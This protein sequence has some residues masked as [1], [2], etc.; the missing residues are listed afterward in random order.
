[1]ATVLTLALG[2]AVLAP[3]VI[4][5]AEAA[6]PLVVP[7][8][9]TSVVL[10]NVEA[11]H[12]PDKPCFHYYGAGRETNSST[13]IVTG[14][15]G[16]YAAVSYGQPEADK[17]PNSYGTDPMQ[18][19][20]SSMSLKPSKTT[21][22]N[23]GEPFLLGTMRHN[24]QPIFSG[25]NTS[26]PAVYSGS[27]EIKTAGT[28][29]S[30]FPWAEEDTVNDCTAELD[31]YGHMVIGSNGGGHKERD[32]RVKTKY[33][34]NQNHQVG[35][36]GGQYIYDY[37]GKP[38]YKSSAGD[39]YFYSDDD[40]VTLHDA[41]GQACSDD[42]LSIRSDRSQTTWRDPA[43]GIE[44]QLKIWGFT[45]NGEN[46]QCSTELAEN[47]YVNEFFVT[48]EKRTSYGCLYGSIEQLRPITFQTDA[49]ADESV[50]NQL[51]NPP[52]FDYSNTSAPGS[53]G[54][55]H[56]G[57]KLD[58]LTPT[59]W[60]EAGRSA[61][62]QVYTL[63]APNDLASATQDAQTKQ[64]KVQADGT[65]T[66]SGWYLNG[67][68]CLFTH[69]PHDPLLMNAKHGGGRLDR[70]NNVD[71]TNRS[72]RL[73]QSELA[74]NFQQAAVNCTWHNE[75]ILATGQLTLKNIVDSGSASPTEWTLTATPKEAG[76]FGQKIITGA[77][78]TASV[79]SQKTTGGTYVLSTTGGP[80]GYVQ[81]GDWTCTGATV[82]KDNGTTYAVLGEGANAT[83]TIHHK[84]D[85]TPVNAT[86]T[87]TGAT[88]AA[89][90]TEY[91][92]SYSCTPPGGGPAETGT[93]KAPANGTPV[94][95]AAMK[96]GA[97]CTVT[98]QQLTDAHLSTPAADSGTLTWG[99][100]AFAVTVGRNGANQPVATKPV[101][102]AGGNGPGV[103]F[104]VPDTTNG[105]L[106]VTV[107]NTVI[108]HA[109]VTKSFESVAKAAAQVGGK[110]TFDQTY[111]VTVKNPST[112]A[113]L[114]YTLTDTVQL[115]AGTTVNT[116]TITR[117]D[118]TV[119]AVPA[120][121]TSWTISDVTLP[122]AGTH[123]YTAVMN[124]SAPDP[125]LP[126]LAAGETC[127][128]NAATNGKAVFNTAGLTTKGDANAVAAKACGSVP[129]NPKFSVR[130]EAGAVT[131][132]LDGSGYT[133][134]YTVTVT[135]HSHVDSTIINDVR[136]QLGLPAS[137]K[138]TKAEVRENGNLVKTITGAE[139]TDPKGFV[140]AA[141]GSGQP[142]A[143][144]PAGQADG[145]TRVLGVQVHFTVDPYAPGFTTEDYT[146]GKTRA[147]G[148][149]AGLVNTAIM[150][151]DVDG[152]DNDTACLST[153]A[154]LHFNKTVT[155]RPG[156]G[157]TFDVGYTITVENQG[158][159]PGATGTITD[160]PAFAP[161]L[162]VN[163]VT[164]S[165]DGS[166]AQEVTAA[167]G[168]YRLDNGETI[169]SGRTLTWVVTMNVTVDPSNPNYDE[170]A[171]ACKTNNG[172][173]FEDGHGLLNKLITDPGKDVATG[174]N[175]NKACVDVD[176]N[177]GKR[178]FMVI[179]TGSQGNLDGAAFDLYS[180]D[181]SA[182][183][184]TPVPLAVTPTG[185][186][187]EFNVAP[188]LINR[189][190][191][192]VEKVAPA[193]HTL[194]ANPVHVKVTA[195]GIQVL[196]GNKLGV[197]TATASAV[198]DPAVADTLTIKD[199]EAARL[200]LSG[201]AGFLPHVL[202]AAVLLGGSGVL[203]LRAWRQSQKAA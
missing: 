203:A 195:T 153:T 53:Y 48:P 139:L 97:T 182:A 119:V 21:T 41:W 94:N 81:N 32:T 134:A 88:D 129:A 137:A 159:L 70:S 146:C 133:A 24:N 189:E 29:N 140:L 192:L 107:T 148:K 63:L 194:L 46:E 19:R 64:A 145:G 167:N 171:L 58:S 16:K 77:A 39:Y 190:Y 188:Q 197:S 60:G 200:P 111:K 1:M 157:S 59:S 101:A 34:F 104:T 79:T 8:G 96:V 50:R 20:Q 15:S 98:E 131:R 71:L 202:A 26:K 121:T 5:S 40:K 78:N 138:V 191:W 113:P 158:A 174:P 117:D 49:K 74:V 166:P 9:D 184:A 103:E 128:A 185:T 54:K 147:D 36:V 12:R 87:V 18:G 28:I 163:K 177:A 55:E 127:D 173:E 106:S 30:D 116:T 179:K 68:D 124:V 72:L 181:P 76:L 172:G 89:K 108:P 132:S 7:L 27:F 154:L 175:H 13:G 176:A 100:P 51:G 85:T 38:L 193:G 31:Q 47:A 4:P 17:C 180:T 187:G 105:D 45:F 110:D 141:A 11:S 57:K 199:I 91:Q 162:V 86:K 69:P 125:G 67:I 56:W 160:R 201:G 156:P 33:A 168:S 135:N 52:R 120:G 170:S 109:G 164:V 37:N 82:R 114:T 198:A 112:A 83:C 151:G 61:Q 115:P 143:Q 144:A 10:K 35:R 3:F 42:Y 150:A 92:L 118:G 178:G 126:G 44:Y 196:N 169:H 155:T 161:G 6:G 80:N 130:K 102:A 136:D 183:G 142:L 90:P 122:A 73:D 22:V 99:A 149:P 84:T 152:T 123:T 66:I 43:T 2:G 65:V 23:A 186:K 62:S 95:L 25:N 93:A 165:K 14:S 75:Y